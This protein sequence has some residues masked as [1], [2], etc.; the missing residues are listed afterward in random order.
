VLQARARALRAITR[1]WWL[2]IY[3]ASATVPLP[4]DAPSIRS[5]ELDPDRVLVIG[6]GAASGWGVLTYG[7]AL[8]GRLAVALQRRTGR[9]C[10]VDHLGDDVMN[11]GSAP[12][13]IG[14]RPLDAYDAVVI[15]LGMSDAVRQTSVLRWRAELER[16]LHTVGRGTGPGTGVVVLGIEP[17]DSAPV[18]RGLLGRLGQ[19]HAQRLNPVTREVVAAVDGVE[20]LEL[21]SA[22][23][24]PFGGDGTRSRYAFWAEH[25][26]ETVEPLLERARHS[27][28]RSTGPSP[29]ALAA[30]WAPMRP[31]DVEG[32]QAL[33][34]RA[35]RELGA[36]LAWVG[37]H[38]RDRQVIAA[39]TEDR[40]PASVP[41]ELTFCKYTAE[42][43]DTF[44]VPN[45]PADVRFVGNPFLDV[46]HLEAYAGHPLHDEDG[47]V[48]GTFCIASIRPRSGIASTTERLQAYARDAEEEL[49]RMRADRV[50]T[51]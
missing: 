7:L 48:I 29:D 22:A 31:A 17:V 28:T 2:R 25:V 34:D 40:T 21:P 23:A 12:D 32:L 9:A 50:G 33:V 46:L 27:Q 26:A 4:R 51:H 49:G 35:K 24:H 47:R 1:L 41:L 8:G 16:L 11:A 42:Q 6:N 39:T 10:D 36:D 44:V 13:W 14:R 3:T 37:L 15:V 5:G 45:A 43:D 18:F 38:S 20:Y 30:D 19:R